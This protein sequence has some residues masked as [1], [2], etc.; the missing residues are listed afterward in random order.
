MIVETHTSC[1]PVVIAVPALNEEDRVVRTLRALEAEARSY[2][3]PATIAVLANNCTDRTVPLVAQFAA[4]ARVPVAFDH[5]KLPPEKANAGHARALAFELALRHAHHVQTVLVT[6]DADSRPHPGWL[7]AIN[8]GI[9]GGADA[10]AG[11][12]AF[13]PS[14]AWRAPV[15]PA[16]RLEAR[17]AAL[18]AELAALC[19]PQP[20]NPWPNHIW[21]WGANLAVTKAAYELA[22]GIPTVPLA[23]DRA[24]AEALKRRDCRVKHCVRS[25]VWTSARTQG[26]ARGG[27][28]DLIGIYR[29]NDE[30]PCDAELES[31]G[32]IVLR[33]ESR[34]RFREFYRMKQAC[35][36]LASRLAIPAATLR[37]ALDQPFCG[38]G[39][40][41]LERQSPMLSRRRLFPA[42]LEEECRQAERMIHQRTGAALAEEQDGLWTTF[43][44]AAT[45]A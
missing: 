21:A 35:A 27:L 33:A 11:A 36:E 39:W 44:P 40:S 43:Q 19:D 20:H 8:A 32:A 23:E 13:E 37:E 1:L 17:Y 29:T 10:V 5:V 24:F 14:E 15:S 18:Q 4:T 3:G 12:I 45:A 6:T 22:G 34:K 31:A 42:H 26:R 28:A 38:E 7:Q 9:Q 41:W 25:R 16:R 2:G 30:Y